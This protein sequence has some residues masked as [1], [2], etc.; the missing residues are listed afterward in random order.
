MQI[1]AR[2]GPLT[3]DKLR[4]KD[5]RYEAADLPSNAGLIACLIAISQ[6]E[7]YKETTDQASANLAML[8]RLLRLPA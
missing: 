4:G 5:G 3:R 6:T 7:Y 8:E 2:S 1:D